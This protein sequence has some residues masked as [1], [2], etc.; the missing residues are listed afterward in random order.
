MLIREEHIGSEEI[1]GVWKMV[2]S[3]EELLYLLPSDFHDY[4]S[5]HIKKIRSERRA[6]EW[7]S[8]RILLLS[9]LKQKKNILYRADG[10]PYLE[11][12][13]HY[14]S[15]SHT[16]N[17]AAVYLHKSHP[18]G[19]DIET[20][21]ERVTKVASKFVGEKEYIHPEQKI[22]HLLLHWSAKESL[23]KV[24][25]ENEIDFKHHLHIYPFTPTTKGIMKATESKTPLR[26]TFDINYEVHSDYVLTWIKG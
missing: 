8:S 12:E 6:I 10:R 5:A 23:F 13:S 3:V 15:I 24:M 1:I 18:V 2:E 14:I 21:S 17:Y 11:D 26:C 20:I 19:I 25:N 7:L 9:L 16:R 22:V 4:A